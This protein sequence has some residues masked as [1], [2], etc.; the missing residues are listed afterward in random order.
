MKILT[1]GKL[2]TFKG[3]TYQVKK[4]EDPDIWVCAHCEEELLH[5]LTDMSVCDYCTT[6][7]AS[8]CYPSR[9]RRRDEDMVEY[10]IKSA[11]NTIKAIETKEVIER[12]TRFGSFVSS[13]INSE[14]IHIFKKPVPV[15]IQNYPFC[16]YTKVKQV[17][18]RPDIK[19]GPIYTVGFYSQY[20]EKEQIG[21][22]VITKHIGELCPG[23]TIRIALAIK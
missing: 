12:L 5:K 19:C 21:E 11:V 3:L 7:I 8:G 2:F 13:G 6:H 16:G 9:I 23:D 10:R 1:S 20:D 15:T 18:Y 4:K 22:T 17:V 14:Y